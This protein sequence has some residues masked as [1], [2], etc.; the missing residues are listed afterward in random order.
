MKFV[1]FATALTAS[2]AV[3]LR[4]PQDAHKRAT[5][6]IGTTAVL[7]TIEL[8][9]GVT[10]QVT[11]E[12][13][14]DLRA[15][16]TNFIDITNNAAFH[17]ASKQQKAAAVTFPSAVT[18]QTTVTPLLSKLSKTNLQNTLTPFSEFQNRY[19]TSTYG[20]QS[21]AWLLKQVQG[22]IDASGAKGA[23][24]KAFNH[25]WTQSSV[26]A[27][28]PGNSSK[29]IVLGAHQDSVNLSGDRKTNRAPGADD[30]GSGSVTI[31]EAM[32]VLLT[33]DA[34]KNGRMPNTIEFHWYSAE[35]AGLLGS[36][37]IFQK[38]KA[39]GKDVKAMLQQ[40]MTGYVQG[41]LDAGKEEA[42]GIITDY[43]DTGLTDFIRKVVKA[44]CAIPSVDTKC[45]YACSDHASAS[46]AGY[47]SAFVFESEFGDDSPYIHSDKDTLATVNWDHMIEHAKLTVGFAYELA[48]AGSL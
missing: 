6:K 13:K 17:A 47:P 27:T 18:Q 32:R 46:K 1:T 26:I 22:I 44:Y 48:F 15:Q 36:Q 33:N 5:T 8:E 9:P 24:V 34:V 40:D 35:E 11:E 39:D 4:I 28:I 14:W 3:A 42:V 37:D 16:G 31:L 41:T 23:T 20:Q 43:V 19:Y 7:H 25:T 2:T 21:S 45:G 38:Y 29:I 10:Q 30:D 12:E